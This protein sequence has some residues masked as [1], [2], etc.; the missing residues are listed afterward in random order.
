MISGPHAGR[1]TDVP[2][3]H[4][5]HDSVLRSHRW[6]TADELGRLPA[7]PPAAGHVPARRGLRP[8]HHHLRSGPAVAPGRVVGIDAV[9]RRSSPRPGPR[10][11]PAG[12]P[13]TFEVGDL[14]DLRFDDGTF[15]VVHA[16]QVLQHVGDPVAALVEMRRV[17]RPGGIVAARDGDYP[18][19]PLLPRRPRARPGHRR[20]RR[21]DP[22]QRGQLGRR[23]A[24]AR[25]GPRRPGSPRWSRP[26]RPG[27]SPPRRTGP[28]GEACGPTGSPSRRWP[29]SCW[30]TASPPRTTSSSFAAA[31]R[32]WAASPDGWFAVAPRRGHLHGLT[33]ADGDSR[34]GQPP[35]SRRSPSTASRKRLG[36]STIG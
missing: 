13:S 33:A 29:T 15:D 23:A 19:I 12:P 20:L 30:P 10:P 32:R 25:L 28:G 16:H 24:A 17:C 7:R 27:A 26:P 14:F 2:Y 34:A 9:R 35:G 21:A 22:G 3:T 4:G 18:A 11:A 6:R 1:M 36:A 5:H 8:G 31:W